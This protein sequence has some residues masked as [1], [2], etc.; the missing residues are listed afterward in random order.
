MSKVSMPCQEHNR[1]YI[2]KL[3]CLSFSNFL[4]ILLGNKTSLSSIHKKYNWF[5]VPK[6][7]LSNKRD[8]VVNLERWVH[9]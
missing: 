1:I 9:R 3:V 5:C 4:K 7:I 8:N 6:N 2:I